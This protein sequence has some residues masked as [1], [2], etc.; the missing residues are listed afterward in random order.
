MDDLKKK[1]AFLD[2]KDVWHTKDAE[3][4]PSLMMADGPHGLRKQI[5]DSDNLGINGSIPSTCFPSASLFACSWDVELVKLLASTLAN[6]ARANGVNI[7]LGP[8]INIKRSPLCG[9]NFEYFSEDPYLTGILS[10]SYV[11]AMEDEGVGTSVKHFFCNNQERYRFIQDS[12]VDE[13][14]LHEIYLKAF[15]M[16][17]AEKP[18]SIMASYNKINGE[19]GTE[20]SLLKNILRDKWGYDGLVIT[21]WGASYNRIN[22]VLNSCDLEMP[23]SLGYNEK[24]LYNACKD[25]IDLREAIQESY[26]RIVKTVNKYKDLKPCEVD[27]DEHYEISRKIASN[28]MVLLKNNNILPLDKKTDLAII[29]AFI[30]EARY[31]GGGSSHINPYKLKTIRDVYSEY[32]DNIKLAQ[33]FTFANKINDELVQEA[34]NVAR[35]VNNVVL[36]MGLPPEFES[37]GFDR[38]SLEIPFNQLH[39]LDEL[40]KVNDNITVCVFSGSVVN[41]GFVERVKGLIMAYLPGEAYGHAL[42]DVLF[43]NVNPSGCLV[44]T[45]IDDIKDCN[46]QLDDSNNAVYYDESIFVGYRYY[47]TY[48][49]KVRFPFGYGLSYTNFKYEDFKVTKLDNCKFEVKVKVTN[50]G[51]YKGQEV[52]QLYIENNKSSVY[53]A[54]RELKAFTKISLDIKETKEVCFVIDEEAFN[55][56]DVNIK[57]FIVNSGNYKIQICQNANEVI[58]SKDVYLEGDTRFKPFKEI[59]YNQDVYNTS[60]FNLLFDK[61]L[62]AKKVI[63][64]RPYTLNNTLR[65]LKRTLI[66]KL[67][68]RIIMKE[69][70]KVTSNITEGWMKEVMVRTMEE[71][72]LRALA[73]MSGGVLPLE[74]AEGIIAL[75]N[76]RFIKGIIKII[77]GYRHG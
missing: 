9:R 60:D 15:K 10:R 23:T 74:V 30:D 21:D 52:V 47:V 61:P 39:L 3:G 42:L 22:A 41:L 38:E 62:P 34:V 33:G 63:F 55:Y 71:T 26:E 69:S 2:G 17:V 57:D 31:Q 36:L 72:P 43:G 70:Q 59:S 13:R 37:E 67:L 40:L 77:R 73:V 50:I 75:S 64:K 68:Y 32:S 25:N 24:I 66:G 1:I 53:K 4:I 46:V 16:C 12:I 29:G 65:D 8:A 56:Y 28:S 49:Q 45:F 76:L 51:S 44:E 48:N 19:Y 18:A 35:N 6:E 27:Y 54:K 20:H 7:V 11:R 5:N 14:A 58:F